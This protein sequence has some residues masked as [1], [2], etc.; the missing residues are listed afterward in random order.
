MTEQEILKTPNSGLILA[1]AN[2]LKRNTTEPELHK[3]KAHIGL[4]LN[5]RADRNA[6]AITEEQ[7]QIPFEHLQD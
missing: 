1:I 4:P 5:E 7:Q 3:V 6:K 2:E